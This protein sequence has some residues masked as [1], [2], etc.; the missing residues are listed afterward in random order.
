MDNVMPVDEVL[1]RAADF[2]GIHG[3]GRG[4]YRL[5]TGELCLIGAIQKAIYD[6]INIEKRTM[7]MERA[8]RNSRT[9]LQQRLEVD[10]VTWN[11]V[12]CTGLDEATEALRDAAK[13]YREEVGNA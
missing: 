4:E 7:M 2:L 9:Y 6:E 10:V 13:Y 3:W 12:H 5:S 11:D 8:L 1:D